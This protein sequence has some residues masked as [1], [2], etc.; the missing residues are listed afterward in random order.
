MTRSMDGPETSHV[1]LCA[2]PV[3]SVLRPSLA[4]SLLKA[5]L[6]AQGVPARVV[7]ACIDFAERYG[8]DL[9]E[10][11]A[12]DLPT[13]LLAGDWL[14]AH[15]LDTHP[16]P[17][18]R[19]AHEAAIAGYAH[20][21]LWARMQRVR[22]DAAGF[23]DAV[24]RDILADRPMLVGFTTTFQ[25]TAAAL[26][27]AAAVKRLAPG[28]VT[29][30][31]GANCHGPMGRVLVEVFPQLDYAF[32]GEADEAF[33]AFVA[34]LRAGRPPSAAGVVAQGMAERAP[35]PLVDMD[36]AAVPDHDDYFARLDRAAFR[37]AV[38]PAIMIEASRGC[39]WGQKNH[40]TF[41]GLNSAGMSF[42]SKPA[43]R[44]RREIA[45][46][47]G[48]YGVRRFLLADNIIALD[49]VRHVFGQ[50]DSDAPA[51][52]MF[53]EIKSNLNEAAVR[54]LRRAGVSWVQPGIES[55]DD[56]VLRL[57]RKG[58]DALTNVRLLRLCRE[59][60]VGAVWN[61]LHG[62]PGE[63]A[64]AYRQ[65]ADLVPL[66]EH[67]RPPTSVSAI[68]LDRFSPN[69]EQAARMGFERVRPAPAYAA[70]YGLAPDRLADLAYFFEGEAR[71]LPGHD[72][73]APL[74]A[75]VAGWQA[76]WYGG[77]EVPELRAE[78]IGPMTV[79]KD[80]R[81]AAAAPWR[82]LDDDEVAVLEAFRTQ[83]SIPVRLARLQTDRAMSDP[84]AVFDRLRDWQLF[85]VLDNTAL[86]LVVDGRLAEG[87]PD[88]DY[89]WGHADLDGLDSENRMPAGSADPD[90]VT[91]R[92]DNEP[93]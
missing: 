48:R 42:R 56:R 73:V 51:Y 89:P 64:E 78:R 79:L 47:S 20:A 75:A 7:Y 1:V 18:A 44:V 72:Y 86:S 92:C 54:T 6:A 22:A 69:Y 19:A 29:C 32:T 35:A 55:L 10:A 83:A 59:F 74:K 93:V 11:L 23:V 28:V 91:E 38:A 77:R 57:M 53:C 37:H 15:L 2:P 14:F 5:S 80:T 71:D 85:L 61:I 45:G 46:L 84:A 87:K 60:G 9:N 82:I 3:S 25:Q 90:A 63:P 58:V 12:E 31:G 34:D 16:D 67:L 39:W 8:L 70:L 88:R 4:L 76:R 33:P 52:R 24:A 21:G 81:G 66:V 13:H 68:R 49:H 30:I 62:F 43:E 17:E 27:I 41:C 40:C 26:A 65:M 50:L 36:R